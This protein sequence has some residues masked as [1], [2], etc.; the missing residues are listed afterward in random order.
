M[1]QLIQV[2]KKSCK[3]MDGRLLIYKGNLHFYLH[4][5]KQIT[6]NKWINE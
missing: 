1:F 4:I 3:I 5:V 6:L 2:K